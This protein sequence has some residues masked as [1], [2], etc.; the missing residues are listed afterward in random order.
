M[1]DRVEFCE[2]RWIGEHDRCQFVAVDLAGRIR[3]IG[4]EHLQNLVVSRLA[5][6]HQSMGDGVGVQ[7]RE[8]KFAENGGHG[9]LAASDAAG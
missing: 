5:G 6:F 2:F 3:E 1:K 9:A 8:A 7:N 4:A